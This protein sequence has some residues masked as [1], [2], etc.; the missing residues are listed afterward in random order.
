MNG[1]W[2]EK[3]IKELIDNQ[4]QES[5]HIDYK[6]HRAIDKTDGKKKE[7]TKDV[8]AMANSDGG[9]VFYGIKEFNSKDKKHL[10]EKID[11]VDQTEFSKEWLQQ[12]INNIRPKIEGIIITPVCITNTNNGVV[13]VVEIP[14]SYTAHQA[15]DF[16][17]Y[18]RYNSVSIPLSDYEIRDIMNRQSFPKFNVEFQIYGSLISVT[19][20]NVGNV[21]AKYVN[22]TILVPKVI[23]YDKYN[24]NKTST[25]IDN[26]EYF[27]YNERNT[28]R[29]ILDVKLVGV[30]SSYNKYGT[31][32]FNPILPGLSEGW[33]INLDWKEKIEDYGHLKVYW[34][35]YTDNASPN[36]GYKLLSEIEIISEE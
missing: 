27:S 8:S 31:S 20:T 26:E 34:D 33:G 32:W 5:L 14:K 6:E 36:V 10:P 16:R 2:T 28:R 4:V 25:I 3:K 24:D 21:Y 30:N 15:S 9:T 17:Y 29:D 7:I 35:L 18:K 1:K 13:Y 22:M 11:V 23:T 19:I 12:I